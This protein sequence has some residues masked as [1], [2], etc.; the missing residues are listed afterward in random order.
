MAQLTVASL[1]AIL[2]KEIGHEAV[3]KHLEGVWPKVISS[4]KAILTGAGTDCN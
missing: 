1:K 3:V 4:V 2:Q